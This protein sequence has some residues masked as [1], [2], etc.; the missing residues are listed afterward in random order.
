MF[1]WRFLD[2]G[3]TDS[4]KSWQFWKLWFKGFIIYYFI[5]ASWP[6]TRKAH[7]FLHL[8]RNATRSKRETFTTS[9]IFTSLAS[10]VCVDQKYFNGLALSSTCPL[11]VILE[12]AHQYRRRSPV[13][14]KVRQSYISRTVW[15]SITKFYTII[16]TG[17][18]YNHTWYDVTSHFRYEVIGARKTDENDAS[19]GFWWN[20][21][22][23]VLEKRGSRNLSNLSWTRRCIC[24]GFRQ[25][26]Q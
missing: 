21:A 1:G 9:V 19:D 11:N 4:E 10:V 6:R 18:F 22:R 5:F 8:R 12:G 2:N 3:S 7:K 25:D 16:H 13:R 15:P 23:T 24:H 20:F 17:R 14:D 26:H